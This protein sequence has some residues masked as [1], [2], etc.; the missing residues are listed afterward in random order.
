MPQKL[1]VRRLDPIY[2]ELK[3]SGEALS[4]MVALLYLR[5][6]P[7]EIETGR[8]EWVKD[9]T[10]RHANGPPG[11][12]VRCTVANV[13]HKRKYRPHAAHHQHL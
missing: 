2:L 8:L 11:L 12:E 13:T 3:K 1:F 4:E 5:T 10:G 9:V 6:S 7:H